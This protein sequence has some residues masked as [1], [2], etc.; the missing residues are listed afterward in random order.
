MRTARLPVFRRLD[1]KIYSVPLALP[2]NLIVPNL[3]ENGTP[4][5]LQ[6]TDNEVASFFLVIVPPDDF[7]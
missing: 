4:T 7:M 2:T 3:T 6:T 1:A 5:V